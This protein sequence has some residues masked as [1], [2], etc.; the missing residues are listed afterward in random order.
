M[1]ASGVG[2]GP[3]VITGNGAFADILT[4]DSFLKS[5]CTIEKSSYQ[6]RRSRFNYQDSNYTSMIELFVR[7]KNT[8]EK[9]KDRVSELT[10]QRLVVSA[11]TPKA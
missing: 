1:S 8:H 3:N 6:N 11:N 7:L 2:N 4:I 5:I 10:S 9:E